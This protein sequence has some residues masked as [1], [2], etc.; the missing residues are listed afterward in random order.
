MD[1]YLLKKLIESVDMYFSITNTNGFEWSNIPSDFNKNEMS[2][3]YKGQEYSRSTGFVDI[4]NIKYEVT[5]FAKVNSLSFD[6]KTGALT[7]NSF[8]DKLLKSIEDGEDIILCLMDIDDFKK[9]NDTF[10]HR[11]GDLV[12]TSVVDSFNKFAKDS[13]ICRFGGDEFLI[14]VKSNDVG[15][16]RNLMNDYADAVRTDLIAE[17]NICLVITFSMGVTKYNK[18]DDFDT[19]FENVDSAMY[20]CKKHGKNGVVSKEVHVKVLE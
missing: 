4:S 9:I 16:V 13:L 17:E 2:V 18:D 1:L 11:T 15:Y 3:K 10:G 7:F 20:F 6:Q 5:F 8:K 14:A 12:L 19:N